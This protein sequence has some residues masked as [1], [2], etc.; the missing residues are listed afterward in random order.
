M[1]YK[2]LPK[3]IARAEAHS[4]IE[5]HTSIT[6]LCVWAARCGLDAASLGVRR[7]LLSIIPVFPPCQHGPRSFPVFGPPTNTRARAEL[8]DRRPCL[9]LRPASLLSEWP[10]RLPSCP[11]TRT[12][13]TGRTV[14]AVNINGN[15][16]F[17]WARLTCPTILRGGARISPIRALGERSACESSRAGRAVSGGRISLAFSPHLAGSYARVRAPNKGSGCR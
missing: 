11:S 17:W 8:C 1:Y 15:A 13:R 5:Q 2:A 6:T 3:R 12:T 16:P 14:V 10:D 4:S 7:A 9:I